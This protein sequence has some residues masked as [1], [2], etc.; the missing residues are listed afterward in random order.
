MRPLDHSL[1]RRTFLLLFC[2]TAV[3]VLSGCAAAQSLTRPRWIADYDK[4]ERRHREV[5]CEM[6]IWYKEARPG[7]A[8]PLRA[9]F[10]APEL[11]E[12][13]KGYLRCSL[14]RSYE[15]DRRY[16]GQYG[17]ERAPAVIVVH[18]D[19]TYHAQSGR[20]SVDDITRLL[21]HAEP[22]G[23][24]PDSNPYLHREPYYDWLDD[25]DHATAAAEPEN[26]EV[27]VVLHRSLTR[28]WRRLKKILDERTVFSRFADMIHCRVATLAASA[29]S[30][31]ERFGISRLPAIVIVHRDGTFD[32]LEL[33]RSFEAVVRFA[34]EARNNPD[35]SPVLPEPA[36]S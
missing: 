34:D 1:R 28:D 25:F 5:G 29:D 33:P 16:V 23:A 15:P 18:E 21:D 35:Q 7:M 32:V 26:K 31:K 36:G 10:D 20:M 3:A 30:L 13:I 27:V 6:L 17:V 8:D 12:R 19:G 9:A 14:L 22:P 2:A 4:A 11:R 24:R